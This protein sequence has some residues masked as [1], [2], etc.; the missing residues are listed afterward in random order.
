MKEGWGKSRIKV[1]DKTYTI[2]SL[3]KIQKEG[4]GNVE[5]LPYSIRILLENLLRNMDGKTVKEDDV[6]ELANW[7]R[8]YE[9]PKE[10]AF[11]PSRVLMQDFTG[12]PAVAD[13]AAMRDAV[14]ELGRDP[15]LI[16]PL[17]PVSLIIDHSVQVDFFG[18]K[19]AME[20]NM[21]LEYERNR[22]RYSFLKWAQK[23]FR[24]LQ[25]FPPG[26]GIIHQVNLEFISSVVMTKK[27]GKEIIAYP[28]TLIG[29]DSHTTM[30]N[31]LG[32]LGW[33]VGG[34]EAE[35][36]M[37]GQ[38]YYIAIPEVIG[39]KLT[40]KL[41]DGV[42]ATDLVLTLTE[43]LRKRNVVDKFV[44]YFGP[45]LRELSLPDRATIANMAPEYGATMGF[46][47]VDDETLNYLKLTG[48]GKMVPLVEKYTKTQ[49]LFY[50]DK[51]EPEYTEVI[52]FDLSRVEPS[53]AGPSR[54]Q[55]R[56][57]RKE[58][59]GKFFEII[60]KEKGEKKEVKFKIGE[61]E[62]TLGDGSVVIAAITS[63]TNTSNPSVILGAGIAAKKAV[64]KGLRVP[65][66][67]KTSLA[68]GS[69]VVE[70]YLKKSG[71]LKYLEELGFHIV[72][73]GCTTCIGNSG[74]LLSEVEQAI[75]ENNLSVASV[76]SGNR[77]F[78]ARIHPLVRQ[79]YL[80]S[81]I[82]V[83]IYA[84]AGRIDIEFENEPLGMGKNGPVFMKD[85]LP[86]SEEIKKLEKS[87]IS[88][89][90]FTEKYKGIFEG[91]KLWKS[92]KAPSGDLYSWDEKST[93]IKKPPFF[94]GF[95]LESPALKDIEGARILMLLGNSITTDHISPAGSIHPDYPAG[96]YLLERGVKREEFNTYGSRRGNHE[97]M[98]RGT[99][100][101]LRI[102]NKLLSSE[103]GGFTIKLPEKKK[104]YVFDVAMEYMKEGV[105][106]LVIAGKEY[107]TGSS[108]DW[109]AKG[110]AL[111]GIK[112]VIAESFERIHRSN[113]IGMG[114][115][116]LCFMEGEN[117][118]K[119][120]L[121][122][123]ETYTIYGLKELTPGKILK[124]KAKKNGEEII[125]DV[126]CRLDTEIEVEYFINGGILPYVLRKILRE[127]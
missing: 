10:I 12:V 36:V 60:K 123:Y 84:L 74:P 92:L 127:K 22:E 70:E 55:D 64:E 107:G 117:W 63:C 47:P 106:L 43:L 119:L 66:Y 125:F 20:K 24:N 83:I 52:E 114:V 56:I 40:G 98:M 73:F 111:L 53:L 105:N 30:I 95:K 50:E 46:F 2:Y 49:M 94:E 62:Y 15:S 9:K 103:E 126:K 89:K 41:P 118:E 101:N 19:K 42:T 102:K 26:S 122:G 99:F 44:E 67:V 104:G 68:P 69:R 7:K 109:A 37:L 110:T 91:D 23:A 76:L 80:V 87:I 3:Q 39:V 5:K 54:P 11:Y 120:G 75:K 14:K 58:L 124:V 13:L 28:D 6:V 48:R 57:P 96:K 35:A 65:G 8:K 4:I 88:R 1:K 71:L 78:E 121:T 85:I 112:A 79:N 59:K 25:I 51:S 113:L 81:P 100:A 116:P 38:P 29:T 34:I 77:N 86:S 61:Q 108:R 45:A 21:K 97:V 93:Y 82:G 16:N 18:E 17:V 33:G 32:V 31:G 115:L 90:M 27:N 72:G